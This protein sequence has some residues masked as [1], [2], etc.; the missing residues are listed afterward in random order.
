[1]NNHTRRLPVNKKPIVSCKNGHLNWRQPKPK[2][3]KANLVK[4]KSPFKSA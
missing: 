1:M 4:S 3:A 2:E